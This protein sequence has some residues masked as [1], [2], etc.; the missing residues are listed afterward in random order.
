MAPTLYRD[1]GYSLSF[2]VEDI[3]RGNL[4]LPDIQRPFVWSAAKVRD[5]FDSL[6]KGFPV[7]TLLFW[8]TGAET[9]SRKIGGGEADT[10]PRLLIVD[11]QQRLTSLY[12]VLT[13][14]QVLTSSYEHRH[15]RIAFRPSD[16]TFEVA[17]AAI[18][19]DPEFIP[20]ITALWKPGYKSV[21][22][23]F[24]SRLAQ[25][26]DEN[27]PESEEDELE[28]RMDRVRDLRD[29]RFQTI[30]LNANADEEQVADIFVRINSEGVQLKQADFILTLMSV[31]WEKGRQQLESFCRHAVDPT[32]RGPSPRN[33]FIDPGPDQLLRAAVG[34]AF[35]RARLQH[36]Y[37]ILR[38]KDLDTGEVSS[39]RRSEQFGRLRVALDETLDLS[40]WH[41][42]LKCLTHAG[43]RHKRMITSE[44]ALVYC[45]VIWLI[46]RRDFDLDAATL[47]KVIARW[48]F[49]AQT[50]GRYTGSSETA[51]EAD[52]N[53]ISTLPPNDGDAFCLDLDRQIRANF[54]NDYWEVSFP[55][56]LDSSS[57]KSPALCAY[58]ASLNVLDA[59]LLFSDLRIRDLLDGTSAPRSV[60]RHHLFPKA[61]L[62]AQG[63]VDTRQVNAIAN[64]AFLDWPQN[65][66]IGSDS[67][68]SYW[69]SMV[70]R[71]DPE[72][73]G[74]QV[75]W[76]AL[77][78]GW[79]Q[80]EYSDFLERR[81]EL[82]AQVTRKGFDRLSDSDSHTIDHF[83]SELADL[84]AVG[85]S[86]TA[87]FKS[88]ARVNLH[89][90]AQDK[91]ME[92]VISKRPRK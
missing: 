65:A 22:R 76:H 16:E 26:R 5:L 57:A 51:L 83:G 39:E 74:R 90:G 70:E 54:T 37:S 29:F 71:I 13:G 10:V 4:A 73:L 91:R 80:L 17:D 40:N 75:D 28:E 36:V 89:T 47:R 53:R 78:V 33:A 55:N 38:G 56:R 87:E 64:M 52:L 6:Y 72:Q 84:L 59:E 60:E 34:L 15:I 31:H 77:P 27:L 43:F 19:R 25:G 48:F 49:M 8:E 45:Y 24:L 85:E 7:G 86:Q 9:N 68:L 11:G 63:V 82:M 92:H 12:A 14:Q 58:W 18:G 61:Y 42:Y 81:R 41:E 20:D 69:P 35:R 50:T 44:T 46:G 62:K 67:P 30:E 32:V 79:E 3:D 23:D 21:V 88:T 66:A 1:T 2:L